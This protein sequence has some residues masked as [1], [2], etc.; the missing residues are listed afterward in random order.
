MHRGQGKPKL[1]Y[2]IVSTTVLA[3]LS[4]M[5]WSAALLYRWPID[6]IILLVTAVGFL[7]C[8]LFLSCTALMLKTMRSTTDEFRTV[9]A[10]ETTE[11]RAALAA[12]TEAL[13][14]S[15]F[16]VLEEYGDGRAIDAVVSSE[17]RRALNERA[18]Q[19]TVDLGIAAGNMGNVTRLRKR[20]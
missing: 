9:V 7:V 5:A 16:A 13:H 17:Y 10:A 14:R 11:V 1:F 3:A 15:V 8:A 18:G 20:P 4:A 6:H 2:S 19:Q 12:E